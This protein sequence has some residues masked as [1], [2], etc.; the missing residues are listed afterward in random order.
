MRRAVFLDRDNTIIRDCP[1]CSRREDVQLM[2]GAAEAI[3]LL[4]R[5]QI[6]AIVI[7]NQSGIGRGYFSLQ[8]MHEVNDEMRRQLAERGARLDAIYYCPHAP[9]ESCMCRKPNTLLIERARRDFDTCSEFVIGDRDDID[10]EMA[11]RAGLRYGIVGEI[12][13]LDIIKEYIRE[14]GL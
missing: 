14:A 3:S 9:E 13:I 10:G 1:Y 4:N 11:R 7:T 5:K 6:L 8:Q 12:G 2:E